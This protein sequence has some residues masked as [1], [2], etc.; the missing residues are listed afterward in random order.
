RI[1]KL[2]LELERLKLRVKR[3]EEERE[4]QSARR[5]ELKAAISDNGGDRIER[6]GREIREG[7]QE[8]KDRRRRADSYGELAADLGLDDAVSEEIFL[9]NVRVLAK[10][11][12]EIQARIAAV[13]NSRVETEVAARELAS[14][15]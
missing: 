11:Q 4:E 13:Q 6:L 14:R 1:E 2:T 8:A 15:L 3:H 7:Q 9:S 5:D 10:E 12:G